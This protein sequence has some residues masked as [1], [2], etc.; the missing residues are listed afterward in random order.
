MTRYE[1]KYTNERNTVISS[2]T[3][4]NKSAFDAV[5]EFM[6]FHEPTANIITPGTLSYNGSLYK[7]YRYEA[8][9]FNRQIG[10]VVWCDKYI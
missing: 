8:Y 1:I 10:F 6:A 7:T 2:I 4:S 3:E 5:K 9:D